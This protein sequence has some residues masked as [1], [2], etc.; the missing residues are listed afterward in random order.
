MRQWLRVG[1]LLVVFAAPDQAVLSQAPPA[2]GAPPP[3]WPDAATIE[4]RRQDAL[5][6]ALFQEAV[7]LE[8]TLTADFDAVNKDRDPESIVTFPATISFAQPDGTPTTR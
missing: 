3:P 1:V 4:D 8:I 7:P 2:A 6:R 5:G